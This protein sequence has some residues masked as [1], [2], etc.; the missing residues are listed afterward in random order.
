MPE[1]KLNPKLKHALAFLARKK[2]S[3]ETKGKRHVGR[4]QA[5]S[6]QSTAHTNKT[7]YLPTHTK[8]R[9]QHIAPTEIQMQTLD[10]RHQTRKSKDGDGFHD[11]GRT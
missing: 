3:I 2:N 11:S 1:S 10:V 7:L 9:L 6:M 5:A 4:I 8:S